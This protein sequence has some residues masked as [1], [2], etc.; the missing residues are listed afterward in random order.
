MTCSSLS[1]K[2]SLLSVEEIELM[3]K[4]NPARLLG[5]T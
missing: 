5:L 3:I 1:L 4:V 2:N